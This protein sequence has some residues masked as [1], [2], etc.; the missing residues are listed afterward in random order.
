MT[1]KIKILSLAFASQL[2]LVSL[3]A[4]D[5]K[6]ET[7]G[8]LKI[9]NEPPSNGVR[10]LTFDQTFDKS[11]ENENRNRSYKFYS[12]S[13]LMVFV[14]SDDVGLLPRA[15]GSRMFHLLPMGSLTL[16]NYQ[17][18]GDNVRANLPDGSKAVFSKS[19]GE[20][21]SIEGFQVN[22]SPLERI[23]KMDK[24]LGG[25][26]LVPEQGHILIDY[27]WRIGE[28]PISQL[29]RKVKVTD[30]YKNVCTLK[31]SEFFK[32]DPSGAV[33]IIFKF[34]SNDEIDSFLKKQCP[35]IKK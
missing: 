26:E 28:V 24:K 21:V 1:Q 13:M 19:S 4:D 30:S 20:L 18:D 22:L 25:I 35:K 27:G 17:Q 14:G 7:I 12:N 10:K 34:E 9:Q 8:N 31:M 23:D 6:Q 2:L 5:W 3:S 11:R 15:D 16:H 32:K 29:W 33:E